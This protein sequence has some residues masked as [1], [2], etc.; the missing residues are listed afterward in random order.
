MAQP[1][2]GQL[3]ALG[4]Q[5]AQ[6][7]SLVT[8]VCLSQEYLG[9]LRHWSVSLGNLGWRPEARLRPHTI[10]RGAAWAGQVGLG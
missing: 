8:Q 5:R 6:A 4:L 1:G 7:S 10:D 3:L 2:M 9:L